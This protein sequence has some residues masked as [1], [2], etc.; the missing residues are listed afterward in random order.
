MNMVRRW[1]SAASDSPMITAC[2]FR[3]SALPHARRAK[4]RQPSVGEPS[5]NNAASRSVS[6]PGFQTFLGC[7]EPLPKCHIL[8]LSYPLAANVGYLSSW[9]SGKVYVADLFR[10]IEAER[11]RESEDFG[12]W[13]SIFARLLD[14][15]PGLQFDAILA[16]D[17]FNYLSRHALAA[18]IAHLRAFSRSGMALFAMI[19]TDKTM[20]ARPLYCRI[21]DQ[22]RVSYEAESK[23]VTAAP[24]YSAGALE[25]MMV[26]FSLQRSFLLRHG[27]QEYVYRRH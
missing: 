27:V 6:S 9:F 19:A 7:L 13:E 20:S 21:T 3:D 11:V 22:N 23:A 26:G 4:L 14:Y 25:K 15:P 12:L 10:A 24:R 18:L 17:I 5:T 8:D 1:W 16:W 2:A